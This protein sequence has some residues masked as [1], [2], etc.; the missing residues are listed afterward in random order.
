VAVSTVLAISLA[1]CSTGPAA[2]GGGVSSSSSSTCT[3]RVTPDCSAYT[4]SNPSPGTEV[5]TAPKSSASNNREFF[6][7]KA[8]RSESDQTVC[9]S[10]ATGQGSDQQGI[11]LR[12]MSLPDGKVRA[13]TVTRN[14]WLGAFDVFNFHVWN[15]EADPSSP[16]TQF[17]SAVVS[18]LPIRP[19]VYPLNMCARTVAATD[20]VQFVIWTRG[21]KEPKWGSAA[22]GEARIPGAAPAAGR[23]GW[24][25]GHLIPGS[26]MTYR[27]LRIDGA[28]A[29][30]LP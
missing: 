21:Q 29:Q 6:W 1:D 5:V 22:G 4:Y 16:F 9:A 23:G 3:A 2:T 13:I 8:G 15:T 28:I 10:F 20:V 17:G 30:G 26:S 24:F 14:I 7:D 18:E 12:L 19:A 11:V 27:R 25:A